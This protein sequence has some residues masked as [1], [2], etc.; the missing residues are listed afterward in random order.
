LI[1][2]HRRTETYTVR[3]NTHAASEAFEYRSWYDD[4]GPILG[5][6]QFNMTKVNYSKT[7]S[8]DSNESRS[9]WE[10]F[11]VSFK[12]R[13]DRD[14]H[15]DY[16]TTFSFAGYTER[17][18]ALVDVRLKSPYLSQGYY[19]LAALILCSWP[20][21]KWLS[22]I[23]ARTSYN[24]SKV[25]STAP[26]RRPIIVDPVRRLVFC[27]RSSL[28][29]LI[30]YARQECATAVVSMPQHADA[31]ATTYELGAQLRQTLL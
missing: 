6:D 25:L 30:L 27:S 5:V 29:V 9:E 14:V 3:V 31:E 11:Q 19:L 18:L 17:M 10:R 24:F 8:F 16:W 12:R 7:Y 20:Y 13:N 23:T 22:G 2:W 1:D 15:M 28:T 4:S 26:A 21:R